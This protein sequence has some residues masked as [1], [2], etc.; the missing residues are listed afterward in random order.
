MD[1][2]RCEEIMIYLVASNKHIWKIIDEVYSKKEDDFYKYYIYNREKYSNKSRYFL[3]S[4]MY[5]NK[6]IGI[7]EYDKVEDSINM[8]NICKVLQKGYNKVYELF[9][10]TNKNNYVDFMSR[11]NEIF[12][13]SNHLYNRSVEEMMTHCFVAIYLSE[14]K[15][16]EINIEDF[17]L[18]E[19]EAFVVDLNRKINAP[20]ICRSVIKEYKEKIELMYEEYLLITEKEIK[21]KNYNA[22]NLLDNIFE[23]KAFKEAGV[24][25]EEIDLVFKIKKNKNLKKQIIEVKEK[26]DL[27][28]QCRREILQSDKMA[29]TTNYIRTWM[30]I[31]GLEETDILQA[32]YISNDFIRLLFTYI[33]L[34]KEQGNILD[35]EVDIF[36]IVSLFIYVLVQNY[37]KAKDLYLNE[38][39]VEFHKKMI[40]SEK[41]LNTKLSEIEKYKSN[42]KNLNT[43]IK[44]LKKDIEILEKDHSKKYK[45]L[46][47]GLS[48]NEDLK[49]EVIALRELTYIENMSN[50][51]DKSNEVENIENY[52]IALF[53]GHQSLYNKLNEKIKDLK[54]ISYDNS[55]VDMSFV[56]NM[57]CVIVATNYIS[58]SLYYK[59]M[60]YMSSNKAKLVFINNTNIN[61]I[62]NRV[63]DI[64]TK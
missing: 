8:R 26:S 17:L 18:E 14:I 30:N 39:I 28:E 57:D 44:E 45:E 20:E 19:I 48:K 5:I 50:E 27:V 53:G 58:H 31:L 62:I 47:N 1:S 37:S 60:S 40:K 63:T 55:T 59:L 49:K 52:K 51:E 36:I 41:I 7:I 54:Y 29:L 25:S 64:L 23:T 56:N 16:V 6:L 61:S 15:S 21:N 42:I 2:S 10:S 4:E 13:A 22:L 46:E 12:R 38:S 35:E 11:F 24:S 9:K 34:N 3:N 32:T 33:S 43:Q